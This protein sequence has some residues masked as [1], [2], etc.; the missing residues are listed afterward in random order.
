MLIGCARGAVNN[1]IVELI[2]P[3]DILQKLFDHSILFGPA[4]DDSLSCVVE[5]EADGDDAKVVEGVDGLPPEAALGDLLALDAHHL[6]LRRPADVDVKQ[7]HLVVQPR[8]CEGELPREGALA[9]PP[10]A[11]QHQHLVFD[12]LEALADLLDG[13]VGLGGLAGRAQRLVRAAVAGRHLACLGRLDPRACVWHRVL[14]H[15]PPGPKQT[16]SL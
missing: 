1:E 12:A 16:R 13:G 15:I 2:T 3:V 4:P 5:E 10:L 7:P 14:V 9:H 6:W 8:E 11:R